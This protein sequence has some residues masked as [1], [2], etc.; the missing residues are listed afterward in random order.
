MS[1]KCKKTNKYFSRI[2][3]NTITMVIII[4]IYSERLHYKANLAQ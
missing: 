1:L 4:R 2:Q 3:I